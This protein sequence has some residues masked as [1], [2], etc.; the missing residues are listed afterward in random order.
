MNLK[1]SNNNVVENAMSEGEKM[2]KRSKIKLPK[3]EVAKVSKIEKVGYRLANGA[4]KF[5]VLGMICFITG[6]I[7][8][9]MKEYNNY[10]RARRVSLLN[11]Y[12]YIYI[13]I[14]IC[15]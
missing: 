14:Y 4:H 13:Y 6:N 7:I 10:W 3:A 5:A 12:I 15:C 11:I 9:F 1:E 8:Y 2:S